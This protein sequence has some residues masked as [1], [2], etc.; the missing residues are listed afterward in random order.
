MICTYCGGSEFYEGPTAGMCVNILCSNP[1]CRHWFNYMSPPMNKLEDLNRI[2]PSD[3]EKKSLRKQRTKE[4]KEWPEKCYQEGKSA[5]HNKKSL[6]EIFES[7]PSWHS[8]TGSDL[9]RIAG[10]IEAINDYRA[11]LREDKP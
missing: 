7:K 3:E 2:E 9:W 5:F 1:L 10:Y 6:I 8:V 4:R 11:M